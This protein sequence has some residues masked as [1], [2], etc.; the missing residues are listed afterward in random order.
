MRISKIFAAAAATLLVVAC[1]TP[2]AEGSKEAQ[3]FLPTKSQI[4][5]ASYLIGVNFGSW[6]K[7]NNFGE[8]NYSE[9][10][11]GMKD[12]MKA[13]GTPQD[14]TFFAQFKVD[15]NEMN[16]VLDN[17][18]QKRRSYTK[19]LNTEKGEAYI[20]SFLKEEGR[21]CPADRERYRLQ[22]PRGRQRRE[23]CLRQGHRVGGLQRNPPRR[24]DLR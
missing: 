3:A 12:W 14:S 2:A 1:G 13:K 9:I 4:D 10:V 17:F 16:T 19:A 5:S 24:H 15:P 8:L 20:A 23:G 11:K 6:I 7:G 22:D 18:V 21:G